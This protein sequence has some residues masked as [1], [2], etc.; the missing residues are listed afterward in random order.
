MSSLK[1]SAISALF[2]DRREFHLSNIRRIEFK[3]KKSIYIY[4]DRFY[5]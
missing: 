5:Q 2:F 3:K 4:I 1:S